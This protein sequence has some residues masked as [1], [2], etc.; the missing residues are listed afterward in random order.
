VSA[1]LDPPSAHCSFHSATRRKKHLVHYVIRLR[2]PG[3][4][5]CVV[6]ILDS[7]IDFVFMP[8]RIAQ[9]LL[10]SQGSPK[11]IKG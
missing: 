11:P 7:Q 10:P 3:P 6:D 4:G 5:A 2:A 1:S 9:Y 8:L